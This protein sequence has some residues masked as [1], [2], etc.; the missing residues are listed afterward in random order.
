VSVEFGRADIVV[1]LFNGGKRCDDGEKQCIS[2]DMK[3]IR[4]GLPVVSAVV[5]SVCRRT[6]AVCS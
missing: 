5:L 1:D 3:T 6:K 2:D 4:D